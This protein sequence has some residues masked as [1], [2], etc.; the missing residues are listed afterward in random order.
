MTRH[1]ILSIFLFS[2]SNL[3]FSQT[4][5]SGSVINSSN[6]EISFFN[7]L[8]L[9]PSDSTLLS[10]KIF[11]QSHFEFKTNIDTALLKIEAVGY[12]PSFYLIN[13]AVDLGQIILKSSI[14]NEV[15][16]I[17]KKLPFD[18]KNGNL[19]INV[20]NSIFS[21]S[22]SAQDILGKSPGLVVNNG[23]IMVIGSGNALIYVDGKET[24][25]SVLQTIPVSQIESI[26]VIKN[27][28]ASYDAEGKSVILVKLK[29]LGLE[30]FQGAINS[31]YTNG[32]YQLGYVDVSAQYKKGKISLSTGLNTNFGST[33]TLRK[34]TATVL[35][36]INPY[37]ASS[38]YAEKVK[39]TN[40]TNYLIGLRYKL[41][42]RQTF[43][44]QFNGNY[45]EY[46]LDVNNNI[47]VIEPLTKT[48]IESNNTALSLYKTNVLSA[49]YNLKLDS[50]NSNLFVGGTYTL[51]DISYNDLISELTENNSIS[52][53]ISSKSVGENKNT[54]AL[55]QVD[56][57][58]NFKNNKK[59]KIGAKIN[60]ASTQSAVFLKRTGEENNL[61]GRDDTFNYDEQI[62]SSYI[63]WN[64]QF[65]KS[66]YQIGLRTENTSSKAFKNANDSPYID[67]SYWSIFP[68][69]GITTNFEKWSTSTQFT[70]KISRPKY[71]DITPYI[72]YMNSFVS[73]YGNPYVKPSF[74]YNFEQKFS[75]QKASFSLGYN[76]TQAPRAFLTIQDSLTESRN[77]LQVL[78]VDKLDELYIEVKRPTQKGPLF[79]YTMLNASLSKY[80]SSEFDFGHQTVTPK[81]YIYTYNKV[82]IKK[83]FNFELIGDFTSQFSDGRRTMKP[84]GQLHLG[85][86]KS[87][88]KDACYLQVTMYD[89]FQTARP[90]ATNFIDGNTFDSITT[91]DS[92]FLRVFLS[93]KF[94]KLEQT[95]YEHKQLNELET[96]RAK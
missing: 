81:L 96:K 77:V 39:L 61:L 85:V 41:S 9:N 30:G 26:E 76:L 67:T 24:A 46:D 58:K 54:I 89:I 20:D 47:D 37:N 56:V 49:N 71:S 27:P 33:G 38:D 53:L 19:T 7:I 52:E 18:T 28:D 40:V 86:S 88:L 92:R 62:L 32:F 64:G 6:A 2:I 73:I 11:N 12:E 66:Q 22:S 25:L 36:G 15:E 16:V 59:L 69:I 72:Y 65:K 45:S 4:L 10:G 5:I 83:W 94:G 55:A 75:Y 74:N 23:Q 93:I 57:V 21:S 44:T 50:L 87:F 95:D 13:K 60:Q 8:V 63:N 91:Q 34:D 31:H 78:N 80:T 42:K 14:L 35:K 84:Q 29:E 68:N 48:R 51:V 70:S 1:I 43:S 90:S 82:A 79:N 17:G 3:S